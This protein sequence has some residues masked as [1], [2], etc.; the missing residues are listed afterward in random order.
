[1]NDYVEAYTDEKRSTTTDDSVTMYIE[2]EEQIP[3]AVHFTTYEEPLPSTMK[4]NTDST[5]NQTT[6]SDGSTSF[7]DVSSANAQVGIKQTRFYGNL[8]P[9]VSQT[10]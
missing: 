4:I 7:M 6:E 3:S 2:P 10:V 1:M 9:N 5:S 8:S